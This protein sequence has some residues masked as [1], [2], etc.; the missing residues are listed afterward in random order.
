MVTSLFNHRHHVSKFYDRSGILYLKTR[1]CPSLKEHTASWE[2]EA[3]AT[4]IKWEAIFSKADINVAEVP[5]GKVWEKVGHK[6][7]RVNCKCK[8]KDKMGKK[9]GNGQMDD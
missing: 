9:E 4:V 6:R 2:R 3:G 1:V 7:G 8:L 5:K